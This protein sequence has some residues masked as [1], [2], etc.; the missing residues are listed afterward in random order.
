MSPEGQFPGTG[1]GMLQTCL[2]ATGS[3]QKRPQ[4]CGEFTRHFQTHQHKEN[5]VTAEQPAWA[6]AERPVG[7]GT[8]VGRLQTLQRPVQRRTCQLISG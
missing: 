3:L 2:M 6:G 7:G 4:L 1:L 5:S 8:A